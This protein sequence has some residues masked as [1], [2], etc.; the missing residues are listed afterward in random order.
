MTVADIPDLI[1]QSRETVVLT[2]AGISADSGVPTFREALSGLWKRFDPEQL[3]TLEAFERDPALVWGWY[4][5]RRA[6]VSMAKPNEAHSALARLEAS[7]PRTVVVTQN[8]DDLH[9]RAG[10]KRVVHLH[11]SLFTPRCAHCGNRFQFD[12]T[13]PVE[14]RDGRRIEPPRC[15]LC[16]GRVRPGV[17]WFGE[18][19]PSALW[20]EAQA[21]AA[22]CDL[23]VVVGTSGL[24][25]P[26]ASLPTIARRAGALVLVVDPHP[27]AID[28][29]STRC[30]RGRAA[31]LLPALVEAALA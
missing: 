18:P 21:A 15:A 11:G 2:G 23:L 10:S 7:R 12:A 8:V 31:D 27:T 29:I 5:W 13:V 30:L 4:E 26:A 9:E 22:T 17:V 20:Q 1:R 28:G 14:P 24:V 6:S 3:A 19:L 16:G 25:Q